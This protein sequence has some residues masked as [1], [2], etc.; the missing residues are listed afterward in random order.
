MQLCPGASQRSL[1]NSIRL[2][3]TPARLLERLERA[4]GDRERA[5]ITPYSASGPQQLSPE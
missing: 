1:L 3:G 5:T 2:C 4:G